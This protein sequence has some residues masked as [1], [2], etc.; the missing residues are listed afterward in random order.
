MEI[1][2]MN[3]TNSRGLNIVGDFYHANSD[4]G[5][6][7]LHGFTGDRKEFGKLTALGKGLQKAGFNV[8]SIDFSGSGESDDEPLNTDN[9]AQDF[10]DA[11]DYFEEK[12]MKEIGAF[13]LS[14]G[15]IALLKNKNLFGNRIKAVVFW[16]PITHKKD[17]YSEWRFEDEELKTLDKKGELKMYV[18]REEGR[19]EFEVSKQLINERETLDQKELLSGVRLPILIIHGDKDTLVPL[20]W[21]KSAM[22]YLPKGSRLDIIEGE[23]HTFIHKRTEV[24]KKSVEWF[25]EKM[26]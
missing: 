26:N 16:A 2:K 1:E 10:R 14:L 9:Q 8:L 22:Q 18:E 12:G 6:I 21:S 11:L 20:E 7:L 24:V 3:F 23:V 19:T 4:K 15:P 13:G 25:K 5:I 17:N